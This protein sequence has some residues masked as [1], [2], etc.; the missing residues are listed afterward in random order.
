MYTY[1]T[2]NKNVYYQ[3]Q[4][5]LCVCTELMYQWGLAHNLHAVDI[6]GERFHVHKRHH[7]H[8]DADEEIL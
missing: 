6:I 3:C 7:T 4:E 2:H 5:V 8:L 1:K